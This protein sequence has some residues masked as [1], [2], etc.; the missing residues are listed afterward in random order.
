MAVPAQFVWWTERG[1]IWVAK[2]DPSK[3][4]ASQFASPTDATKDVHIYYYQKGDP[5]KFED[6]SVDDRAVSGSLYLG[7]SVSG[8]AGSYKVGKD[9]LSQRSDIPEQ[10]HEYLVDKA[11]Q[12]GHEKKGT[13]DI[14]QYYGMKFEKG[15]KLGKRFA[16]QARSGQPININPVEF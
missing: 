3:D 5:F 14:A 13:L 9:F 8:S 11:I 7:A 16:Y 4:E 15:V 6:Q 10:F 1:A 12:L 2:Y